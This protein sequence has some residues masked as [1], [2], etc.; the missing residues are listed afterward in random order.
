MNN[1]LINNMI[2]N[3]Y[4]AIINCIDKK[5]IKEAQENINNTLKKLLVSKK[6]PVSKKLSTNLSNCVK[7]LPIYEIQVLAAKNLHQ[8]NI[9]YKILRSKKILDFFISLTGP[10]LEYSTDGELSINVTGVTD[11]YL[12]KRYHQ[13]LWSGMGLSSLQVWI[14]IYLKPGMG[15]IELIKESHTWGHVPH[16]D[17]QPTELPKKYSTEVTKIGEGS[18]IVMTPLTLHRTVAN[19]HPEARMALSFTVRNIYYPKLGNENLQ[20]YGKLNLSYYSKFRKILGNPF[21]SPFRTIS[22]KR[23]KNFFDSKKIILKSYKKCDNT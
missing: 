16:R 10:D 12:L 3:G 2:N 19:K 18:I 23:K 13:E 1:K 21:L 20:E 4:T 14:P 8:N 7:I 15:T 22:S 11:E 5:I 9:L 6:L 17:R